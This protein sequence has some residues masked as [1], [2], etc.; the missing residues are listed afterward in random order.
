MT[1]LRDYLFLGCALAAG[2]GFSSFAGDYTLLESTFNGGGGPASSAH[3]STEGSVGEVLFSGTSLSAS[4]VSIGSGYIAS[5]NEPPILQSDSISVTGGESL[6]IPLVRLLSNDSD[7]EGQKFSIISVAS[8]SAKGVPITLQGTAVF[9]NASGRAVGSDSFT[10]TASDEWGNTAEGTVLVNDFAGSGEGPFVQVERINGSVR[11]SFIGFAGRKYQ[12][13]A[14][15]SLTS[16]NWH[17]I[18][19]SV[20]AVDGSISFID[21][22]AASFP[23][24]FYRTIQ[25]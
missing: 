19:S 21:S 1:K 11:L 9:Y 14:A 25:P 15:E 2:S 22:A 6:S 10:Y 12:I 7:L 20:A 13:Q 8:V 17:T 18:A 16:R 23:M 3:Y 24:R 4:G 5:F